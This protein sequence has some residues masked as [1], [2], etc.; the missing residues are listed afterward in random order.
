MIKTATDIADYISEKRLGE[1]Q[2]DIFTSAEIGQYEDRPLYV[3][4]K[5]IQAGKAP[6][7]TINSDY[8]NINIRVGGNYGGKGENRVLDKAMA[9]YDLFKLKTDLKIN[10]NH[11]HYIMA[12]QP[13]IHSSFDAENGQT[14]YEF[15]LEV[16][17]QLRGEVWNER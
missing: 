11:Y 15:N 1:R 10:G 13:P 17:R 8:L 4:I 12:L 2:R 16:F 14:V 5:E 6:D 9:I 7:T 3:A